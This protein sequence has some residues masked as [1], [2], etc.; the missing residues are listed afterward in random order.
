VKSYTTLIKGARLVVETCFA[1]KAGDAVLVICDEDHRR[2]A[3][4][5][6]GVAVS[7]GAYPVVADISHHVSAALASMK[8]P[9][10]PA[11]NLAAAMEASDVI[12]ITTNLEWANRFA[13]VNPVAASVEK[14]AKIGSVEEGMAEWDLTKED[15]D[16]TV[17]RAEKLMA[18]LEGVEWV[19]VTNPA[20]TDV[21]VCIKDR[22][23]LKV[24]PIK[25]A[26]EMM[27]PVPLWGEVAYAAVEDKTDGVIVVDG[28]MLGVG[29][30]GSLQNTITWVIK[31]GRAVEITGGAEAERLRSVVAGSDENANVVAEFAM[32][33]STKSPR[34]SASEKG[35]L[36][37]VHFALGDNSHC[38]P[39]GCSHSS[40]HLDGNLLNVTVETG[41]GRVLIKDGE[42]V[43]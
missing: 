34:G 43:I 19:R 33:T 12:I 3:E 26:G 10:E 6:A 22:P 24:V 41:D 28:I 38:Y 31:N 9:M 39:G 15:I 35:L 42:M 1:V 11:K 4:A 14:G 17:A 18:A 37:T 8:V 20:G 29:V 40:L 5:V 30:F 27:G 13:H 16:Q 23:P 25:G 2:E 21:K 32:G 7:L 36:G